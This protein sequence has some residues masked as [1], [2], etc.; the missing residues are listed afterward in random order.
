[1]AL[2]HLIKQRHK[3]TLYA[4]LSIMCWFEIVR[5]VPLTNELVHKHKHKYQLD[6]KRIFRVISFFGMLL[7]SLLFGKLDILLSIE[8]YTHTENIHN[9]CKE[10]QIKL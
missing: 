4:I 1:M 9:T 5:E 8:H 3:A 10:Q 7:I 2:S 6:K